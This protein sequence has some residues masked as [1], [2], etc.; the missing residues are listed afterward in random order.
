M[1]GPPPRWVT[2]SRTNPESFNLSR[3][4]HTAKTLGQTHRYNP[5]QE[6]GGEQPLYQHGGHSRPG[7]SQDTTCKEGPQVCLSPLWILLRHEPAAPRARQTEPGAH[8]R[9]RSEQLGLRSNDQK[10]NF[11]SP[12]SLLRLSEAPSPE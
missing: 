6:V 8:C 12:V 2:T 3:P 5:E 9:L 1:C 4:S 10:G 7:T 11:Q